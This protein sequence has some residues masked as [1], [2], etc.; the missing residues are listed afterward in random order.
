MR[1]VEETEEHEEIKGLCEQEEENR[2]AWESADT[3]RLGAGVVWG[4]TFID[5][6]MLLG[7]LD[8]VPGR[9]RGRTGMGFLVLTCHQGGHSGIWGSSNYGA[10][11]FIT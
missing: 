6:D 9:V 10:V 2:G 11:A 8:L 3:E 1:G 4:E 5:Y 7:G